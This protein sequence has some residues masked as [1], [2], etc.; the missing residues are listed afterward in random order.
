VS[1]FNRFCVSQ[2]AL[3]R[4]EER[5]AAAAR[6]R[7]ALLP[8]GVKDVTQ[9]SYVEQHAQINALLARAR[10]PDMRADL[11]IVPEL[12]VMLARMHELNTRYGELLGQNMGTLTRQDVRARHDECQEILCTLA[13]LII[14]HFGTLPERHDVR[15]QLLDLILRQNEALRERRRRRRASRKAGDDA[16][17]DIV[18]EPDDE[19]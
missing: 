9:L 19:A 15:D 5:A 8:R 14:G 17:D 7:N 6:L 2:I 11:A 10:E 1:G 4:G 3:F 16:P 13:C 12:D 18:A